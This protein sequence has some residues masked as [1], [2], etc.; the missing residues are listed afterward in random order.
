MAHK[1]KG[2]KNK[3]LNKK[4]LTPKVAEI[5]TREPS[6]GFNYKQIAKALDIRNDD[7]RKL[8]NTVM[9]E[10]K[11]AGFLKELYTGKFQ[12]H[13]KGAYVTGK[14][15][16]TS[17]GSAYI[18]SD[19]VL[20]D[21][22]VSKENLKS[23]L[24]GDKVKVYVHARRKRKKAEGEVV[25]ILER[26][27]ETFV[28]TIEKVFNY[29]F[30][31]P[32][33]KNMP[34]DIFIPASELGKAKNG[35][36]VIVKITEWTG[37]AKNPVGEIVENLGRAGDNNAEMHAILAEFQLPHKFPVEVDRDAEKISS[38]INEAEIKKRKDYRA[39]STFT[40]DP[41]DAKDFD[42]ALSLQ[43][44]KNGNWEV[45]VHIA[46][47]THYI[48]MKS[49]VEEEA[50]AR[51][52]SVYL[53]DRVVPMLPERLSNYICSLR[54][55]EEKL[56]YSAVFEITDKAQVVDQWFGRT[57]IKSDKRFTYQEAQSILDSG[58]GVFH[59]ELKLL[60]EMAKTIRMERF[61]RGAISFDRIEVKFK[62]DDDGKP[63]G[64]FFKEHGDTNRLIE[65]FMLLANRKVAE[66][67]GKV[68][69]AN[70]A[71]T[72]VY[73]IHDKPDPEKLMNFA[74]FIQRFGYFINPG[75]GTTT[76]QA[77]NSVLDQVEGKSEQNL[78]ETLAVRAMAKAKYSCNNI[79]HYGL[80]FDHYTHFT[81]PIRR[82]PDMMVHRLL[83]A[84]LEGEN[85]KDIN[86]FDKWCQHSSEM[87]HRAALAERASIKYKQVE[88]MQDKLGQVFEGI[89]SG[90]TDWGIYVELDENKVEG[91]IPMRELDD[92]FYVFDESEYCLTGHN[93]GRKFLLGDRIKVEIVSANLVKKQIDFKVFNE[94]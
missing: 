32:D 76:S 13:S 10:M 29:A 48:D 54:P 46:D 8:I 92:D 62:L 63:L 94:I 18:I 31:S 7:S 66:K 12:Y 45:G 49:L 57:V 74:N 72:F 87:E 15:D 30:L 56:C 55:D 16:L 1:K 35:D 90:I 93:N 25:E 27:R 60:N 34:Y 69:N 19:D 39:I 22:F 58:A 24:H 82:Y 73:R 2:N 36:R 51:A 38:E 81:S 67:I 3:P 33:S 79:G 37:R 14:V 64:V 47:V 78:I 50:I 71:K 83:T 41:E 77:I 85:S 65:E 43:K 20:E 17:W 59:E 11:E 86:L 52:T 5:F 42:D 75:G 88:F 6:K 84:Y 9:Y 53:V 21:I 4:Q 80:A 40:I 44:L 89:I 70:S 23:A 26:S 61:N 91:M 68:Q 28:G